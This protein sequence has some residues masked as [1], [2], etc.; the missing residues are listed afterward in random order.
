[1]S[2]ILST[3]PYC[4]VGCGVTVNVEKETGIALIQ[5]DKTHPANY[6]R[7]CSKG[8]ALGETL[9]GANEARRLTQPVV[10]GET[11]S[12]ECATANIASKIEASLDQYGQESVAFYLSGQLLTEDYYVANKL[13]KGF[14]GTANV[15][16]NSRL[17]MS[18]AVAGYKRAFG[19]DT[20]PCS[21]EDLE[22]AELI[23]LIGSNAAWTHPVLYQRMAAAKEANPKLRV[24]LI[25]P[26]RTATATLADLHLQL[27]PS[28]DGYLFQGL[29][30]YLVEQ[31]F[32]DQSYIA[33]NT[34][35]FDKVQ[36]D[37]EATS[38]NEVATKTG[39]DQSTLDTFY[40]WFAETSKTVSFYSQGINQS[41]TGTDKCN[42]II[43]CHLA[44]G[45]IG[46]PGAGPFSI[47]G[48]PNAMGGREVGGLANQLAA[49]MDFAPEDV[50]RVQRFWQSPR[51][52]T[53][54]GLKAVDLFDAIEKGQIK[55]LW[56]M[57]TN[58]AVSLPD[59]NKVRRALAQCPTVIVSDITHT[60]TTQFANV[61][62]PAMGWGEKDGTVTNSERCIS[63]QRG[64]RKGPGEARP[65][66]WAIA[67][68]AKKLG[69]SKDF[70]FLTAR[71][72]FLE[73]AKLSGFENNGARDF[74]ISGLSELTASEYDSLAPVQWPVTAQKTNGTARMLEDGQFFTKSGR[75]QFVPIAPALAKSAD[76][77]LLL[78]TGRLRDQ[79]HT[80]TRTGTAPSLTAH[81]D[82][83]VVEIHPEDA[84]GRGLK[85]D[86]FAKIRSDLGEV[87]GRVEITHSVTRGQLFQ[88]IHW[89][90]QYASHAVVSNAVDMET[91]PIS[92]QPESKASAV[93]IE[94]Y[95]CE[96][97]AR[98]VSPKSVAREG[99]NYWVETKIPDGFVYLLGADNEIDWRQ[100]ARNLMP[101]SHSTEAPDITQYANPI[102][103]SEIVVFSKKEEVSCLV[104]ASGDAEN[105][106]SFV[107][108]ET[109]YSKPLNQAKKE[110]RGEK[111]ERNKLICGCFR[112]SKS[113]IA[114]SIA[115][116]NTSID[117]LGNSLGCGSKCGSC[118]PEISEL[119][120]EKRAEL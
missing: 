72:I 14:I 61:L 5:G 93:F 56:I 66:W 85:N 41:A 80:M 46:Y 34:E 70:N 97:W 110:L 54:P 7:L 26:R 33:T 114:Q 19:S 117:S 69:F 18:S 48:Q 45:K 103:K 112:T 104:F 53:Q 31:D 111:G 4:G 38:W 90:D 96:V 106:P 47:T 92:G 22:Q 108:M 83:P 73:H 119:L 120:A 82:V 75:A 100:W 51:I 52:A 65:D 91:D 55:V 107:W 94:P 115:G 27:A 21:Y 78:N 30:K 13:M 113:T 118:R 98:V 59:S 44:T 25:D 17:C 76:A 11:V 99:W 9:L 64:F 23:V 105:L 36:R 6:G 102:E 10:D 49:H 8:S 116:G 74:D 71:D 1:M 63:R 68:V 15:D 43:N 16:T 89:S 12:W 28:A 88:S 57:A 24:V 37:A 87:I 101:D 79:W 67:E 95:D 39:L 77:E 109:T 29:M 40:Q 84:R 60:D 58:P 20:V 2:E 81:D 86:Q 3:C 50:D 35:G 62:L 42:A 32:L